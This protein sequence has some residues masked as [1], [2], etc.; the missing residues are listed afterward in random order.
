MELVDSPSRWRVYHREERVKPQ[1]W[2]LNSHIA[3]TSLPLLRRGEAG[4]S[5]E[6][7]VPEVS[8]YRCVSAGVSYPNLPIISSG[9]L[10]FLQNE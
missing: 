9:H 4:E 8:H 5:L 10:A 2:L 6:R 1:Q 7:Y 3:R